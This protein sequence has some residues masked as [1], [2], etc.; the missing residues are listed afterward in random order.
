AEAEDRVALPVIARGGHNA[1]MVR[2][3]DALAPRTRGPRAARTKAGRGVSADGRALEPV[4]GPQEEDR[5]AAF[6]RLLLRALQSERSA[7][8]TQVQRRRQH[9]LVRRQAV[10][11]SR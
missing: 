1:A 6:S 8:D 3:L 2:R 5:L 9:R 4:E 10:P 7:A 11:D